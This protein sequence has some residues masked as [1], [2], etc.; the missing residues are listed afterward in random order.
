MKAFLQA[1]GAVIHALLD[2]ISRIPPDPRRR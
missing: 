2:L 1:L